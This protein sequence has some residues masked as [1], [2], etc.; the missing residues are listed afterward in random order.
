MRYSVGAG[1]SRFNGAVADHDGEVANFREYGLGW[2]ASTE[3]SLITTER[4]ESGMRS[5]LSSPRF[6]GAV[7]DLSEGKDL[8]HAVLQRSRR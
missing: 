2:P 8:E 1:V 6:N 5:R 7:A 4:E 3:P